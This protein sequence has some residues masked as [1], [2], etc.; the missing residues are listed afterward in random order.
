MTS[1]RREFEAMVDAHGAA[2]FGLLRRLARHEHDAE[3][4]FQETAARVWKNFGNRPVLR[5]PRGWLIK[6]A[7]RVFLDRRRSREGLAEVPESF[8]DAK[9]LT[10][11]VTVVH[12]ERAA[13]LNDLMV[14]LPPD[15]R[16]VVAL[17][18]T[19][20]LTIAETAVAMDLAE[21][22]VKSRLNAALN[23]LR[24]RLK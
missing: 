16:E 12:S 11:D 13:R 2:V 14:Q 17:H 24:G 23:F 10:P 3:D 6:I 1:A 18:Y 4:L 8:V 7:Y 21:G 15:A 19:G 20:G 9:A 5:N 22:T